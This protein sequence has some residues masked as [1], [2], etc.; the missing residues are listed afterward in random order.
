MRFDSGASLKIPRHIAIIMDGNGRWAKAR[1]LP[2][3][4]GHRAGAK[5]A[6]NIIEAA[7]KMGVKVLT[8]YTFST[9]N[10]KRPKGEVEALFGLLENY[11]DREA[12]K[13]N[14]NNIK[15]SIIGDMGGLPASVGGKLKNVME[16]T[17]NNTGLTLNLALNYGGRPEIINAVRRIAK[18]VK[19]GALA[20]DD[21]DES[22]FAEYLYTR[23]LPDP[24]LL[25]RTSGEFRIS[26]FL[27]W[28]IAYS[29]FYITKKMWPDFNKND[30][31]K[32]ITEYQARQ[33]RFGA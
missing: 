23:D 28:Q 15:F 29:E 13:L 9:E 8:L 7:A 4:A 20:I 33:R 1:H 17:K 11:L 18:D 31:K 24:D 32:A 14:K 6:Q 16:S 26:N 10:W 25:I 27:L 5:T 2:K 3:I 12:E 19:D 22:R 30:F 21:I